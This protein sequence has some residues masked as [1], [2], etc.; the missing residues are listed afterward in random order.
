MRL[1]MMDNLAILGHFRVVTLTY[2]VLRASVLVST[3][4]VGYQH[5]RAVRADILS[6]HTCHSANKQGDQEG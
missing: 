2:A 6:H 4:H 1:A 5:D 3:G